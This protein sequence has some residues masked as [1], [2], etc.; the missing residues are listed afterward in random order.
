MLTRFVKSPEEIARLQAILAA[1]SFFDIRTLALSI[2]TDPAVVRELLPP[3]LE[4]G[5]SARVTLSVSDIRESNCVGPFRGASVN[6]A[7]RYG[8]EEGLYCLA[9][10]MS[11]G[12]AVTFGRELFAEP[13]KLADIDLAVQF[14]HARGAVRRHGVT[15]MELHGAFEDEPAAVERTTSVPHY[16]FKFQPAA[17]GEGFEHDVRL[18]RVTHRGRTHRFARGTGTVTLRE[19]RHDPLIDIPVLNVLAA[20]YSEGETHTSAEVVA[21]LPAAGFLPWAFTS[22]DDMA[23]WEM[24]GLPALA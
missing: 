18:V 11:T 1:P 5:D 12:P 22:S 23:V 20:T 15:F 3:P 13:K 21:E 6:I 24:A 10:P 7:C 2:E 17:N 9:M 4:P 14:P 19:S 16:Y 8:G